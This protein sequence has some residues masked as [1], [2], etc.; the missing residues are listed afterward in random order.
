MIK[1]SSWTKKKKIAVSAIAFGAIVILAGI[2]FA[3]YYAL[4]HISK[5]DYQAFK[6]ELS[7]VK[8]DREELVDALSDYTDNITAATNSQLQ[9]RADRV[10]KASEAL[11]VS[12][13]KLG[14]LKAIRDEDIANEYKSTSQGLAELRT[15][16]EGFASDYTDFVDALQVCQ[17]VGADTSGNVQKNPD[18]LVSSYKQSLKPCQQSLEPLKTSNVKTFARITSDIYSLYDERLELYE[19]LVKAYKSNNLQAIRNIQN[20]NIEY[21]SKFTSVV[22]L[23]S[24]IKDEADEINEKSKLDAIESV[25]SDKLSK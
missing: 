6:Q 23:A 24:G 10:I 18:K 9:E 19:R 3:T 4:F 14:K 2:G 13:E 8:E 20:E 1:L 21:I 11:K 25:V 15:F 7:T 22:S 16:G 5:N 12:T 17:D